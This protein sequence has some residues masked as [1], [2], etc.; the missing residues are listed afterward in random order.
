MSL[1]LFSGLGLFSHPFDVE[2][3]ASTAVIEN[4]PLFGTSNAHITVDHVATPVLGN[5]H[6]P[7]MVDRVFPAVPSAINIASPPPSRP[8]PLSSNPSQIG[9][10]APS[11]IH[12]TP[13]V[14]PEMVSKE[15][16]P[17][18]FESIY[19]DFDLEVYPTYNFWVPDELSNDTQDVGDRHLDDIP[20]FNRVVWNPAPD[21]G[22]QYANR[23]SDTRKKDV[24][25][26]MFGTEI[27]RPTAVI[28]KGIKFTPAHLNDFQLIK[29]SLAN[30]HLSPGTVHAVVD[31]P[32][33]TSGISHPVVHTEAH[34]FLD[35]DTFL[36][37]PDF[38]GISFE[39][40]RSNIHSL[41]NGVMFSGR[42]NQEHISADL[43]ADRSSLFS[44]KFSV[45]KSPTQGGFMHIQS[46]HSSSPP[47]SFRA[48]T[49]ISGESKAIAM[50]PI[51]L[52]AQKIQAP[53]IHIPDSL[54]T[55]IRAKFVMPS[56]GGLLATHKVNSM[57]TPEHAE[58]ATALAQFLPNL[59]V[60][61]HAGLQ[62][63]PRQIEIPSFASPPG[64]PHIEY[65]GYVLEKYERNA[66]GTFVLKETIDLPH[67]HYSTYIDSKI[68]Y[69][70]VYRYRIRT[71][72]R[73]TR[74]SYMGVMGP[75]P[76]L[77]VGH[78]SQTQAFTPYRSSYFHGEWSKKWAY[79]IV[80]DV[81]PPSPPDELLVRPDS[82]RKQ[83]CVSFKL[84]ENSQKDI[85][86]MRLFRKL[87]DQN[88]SD[89]TGWMEVGHHWGPENVLYHDY[90]VDFYQ[91]NHIRY[92]YAAQ[93]VTRHNEYSPLSDQLATRLNV[94]YATYGE[95][96]VDFVSQAGVK[97]ELHGAFATY[98]FRRFYTE[99]VIPNDALF[100]FTGRSANGNIALDGNKYY[101]RLES[102]DTGEIFDYPIELVYNNQTTRLERQ[103]IAVVVPTTKPA[104]K[105]PQPVGKKVVQPPVFRNW[106][107]SKPL[108]RTATAGRQTAKRG[109]MPQGI[110]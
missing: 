1:K 63:H 55:Q 16:G 87:Q 37:H 50:D 69:S 76:T 59:E 21:L 62:N 105:S 31:M 23:P 9:P 42:L 91:N 72:I 41:T 60:M 10:G 64:L 56:L 102:L 89:L 13:Q 74:P 70:Q 38:R 15:S 24:K 97:L 75:E 22:R 25:P 18:V 107:P 4:S 93:T 106:A 7:S 17:A 82:A 53:E 44:G 98:P 83:I 43:T 108:P 71:I 54:S 45:D 52:H 19:H 11:F 81:V 68:K 30:G 29:Q 33:N 40:M 94:D 84:P 34:H 78:T 49:A 80:M 2:G 101:V 28:T 90:D 109:Y 46:V 39:E 92:V 32:H 104:G 58:N 95:Y 26:I 5:M 99:N 88:G 61:N 3:Q 110:K 12:T 103:S 67:V 85:Y 35:E 14:A 48:R 96:G 47:L 79:G 51:L 65:V 6:I 73:W 36:Q 20:R 86:F 66:N 57:Q 100:T 27:H 8:A 77:Q